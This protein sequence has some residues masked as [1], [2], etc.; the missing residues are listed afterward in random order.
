MASTCGD[1]GDAG[2]SF[3]TPAIANYW[4]RW[5]NPATPGKNKAADRPDYT[6]EYLDGFQNKMTMLAV[7][8]P[9]LPEIKEGGHLST[10]AAGYGVIRF[11]KAERSTTFECWPRNVKM[12]DPEAKQYKDWPIKISQKDNFEI[13]EGFE[14][15]SLQISEKDQVVTVRDEYSKEVISS[16]RIQ[17]NEY[18]PKVLEEGKY[19]LEIGEGNSI[20]RIFGLNAQKRNSEKLSITF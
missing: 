14:L 11:N 6:G 18:Q 9:T 15:P 13:K 12:S 7:A 2:Y 19:T 4:L 1:W 8:N 5:W 20:K 10:R 16:I 3:A 17:G